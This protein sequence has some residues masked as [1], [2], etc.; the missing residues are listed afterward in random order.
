MNPKPA[1]QLTKDVFN[2][3]FSLKRFKRLAEN[4]FLDLTI[5]DGVVK[6]SELPTQF[7][8]HVKTIKKIGEYDD[9][10]G[11]RIDILV[12]NL[13]DESKLQR[14]RTMQR[15]IAAWYLGQASAVKHKDATLVAYVPP[16]ESEW[17]FSFV[18]V[19]HRLKETDTGVRTE[20]EITPARRKSF[21]VGT[22]GNTYTAQ[23]QVIPLLKIDRVTL[24]DIETAFDIEVVTK[25]FYDGV[26][27]LFVKL[28]GGTFGSGASK[29]E[30]E[31]VLK[32]PSQKQGGE[33]MQQFSVRLIGRII[34]CWF[35]R[36]KKSDEGVPLVPKDLLSKEAL[37]NQND[38]YHETLEPL[39]FKALNTPIESRDLE[40]L[41]D[42]F[43]KVPYLNGG[44]FRPQADIDFYRPNNQAIKNALKVPD[45]WL[46]ELFELLER[47]HFTIDENTSV[48]VDLSVDPE[49]LGK[50]FENLL[51]Y[52]NPETEESARKSSGSFYTPREIVDYMVDESLTQYL[53]E[54]TD[55]LEEKIRALISYNLTDDEEFPLTDSD[56][57]TVVDM[58]KDIKILDPACGSGAFPIGALQ[59]I[60]FILEQIDP[61]AKRW[62][63][64]QIEGADPVLQREFE[65]YKEENNYSLMRKQAVIRNSIFGVD[66]QP[67]ATEIARLR[68]FLTLIVDEQ[69]DEN[70][71]NRGIIPLPNLEFKFVTANTLVQPPK[72]KEKKKTNQL[73]FETFEEQLEEAVRDYYSASHPDKKNE[74]TN[75]LRNLIKEKSSEMTNRVL[76]DSGLIEGETY[77]DAYREMNKGSQSSMIKEAQMW[78]S[79]LNVFKN[80]PVDFFDIKYFFP[81]ARDG[82][83]I[84]IGNPPYI[85]T[86]K[87]DQPLK[88][89]YKDTYSDT[90]KSRTDIY[91]YFYQRG[92]ELTKKDTGLLCYITSNKWMRAG[93]GETLR[94][95]FAE[96]NP[97]KLLDFG[98]FKVFDSATVDTNILLI[99]NRANKNDLQAVHFEDD[100]DRGESIMDYVRENQVPLKNLSQD[101][102]FIASPE[103]ITL[104]EKIERVG[105]PLKDWDVEI[106]RGI[107]TGYN[108]AFIIDKAKRDELVAKDE[109]CEQIIK[110]MLRGR[111]I[112]RYSYD[113]DEEYIIVAKFGSHKTLEEEYPAVYD[114]LKEHEDKLK[115][116]AQVK[117]TRSGSSKSDDYPGQHHWLELD[118]NPKQ[119][120]IDKFKNEKLIY[121]ETTQCG[122]AYLDKGE[123]YA[124]K[125]NFFM[126]GE[127]IA[128]ICALLN[129]NFFDFTYQTL[130]SSVNLSNTGFQLNKH[131]LKKFPVPSVSEQELNYVKNL[132]YKVQDSK[133]AEEDT[134]N[135]EYEINEFVMDLYKLTDEE[136]EIIRSS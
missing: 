107:I 28:I 102:W 15:N 114:H 48:D 106:S 12:I 9:T 95:Y 126:S 13:K 63:D 77:E 100:Y 70:D 19:Q 25:E 21:P 108:E 6:N 55:L 122:K 37:E 67:I 85:S 86:E 29:E 93:Y 53:K 123:F 72:D 62:F 46:L 79:Y 61:K 18:K 68:C 56:K 88:G 27:R 40:Y 17:R 4:L 36:E 81:H 104:K 35:L 58:L 92:L 84:V 99:Q 133:Q 26:A 112:D 30:F 69:I 87:I 101:T 3:A 23:N 33:S 59:K 119:E 80:E 42:S 34:F 120:Y 1:R 115:A 132:V 16:E 32:L 51:A 5:S 97:L 39:F 103:V 98:G 121:P 96:K 71:K 11:N 82:F 116:R 7:Q 124:E 89:I 90:Y 47:Y 24:E 8:D 131:A 94:D 54:N 22:H 50:I 129:S 136:K 125:T 117:N 128:V 2:Q 43:S 135:L 127:Q 14:A 74:Y 38:Y 41:Q 75:N 109:K 118:N 130:F 31:G 110:P 76:A 45:E 105:T 73:A 111:N 60:I 65:Q 57:D 44:L 134:F 49:M 78:E 20:T 113:F 66:I 83:D 64:A 91:A 52:I 10:S